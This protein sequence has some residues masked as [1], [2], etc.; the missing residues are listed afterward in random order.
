MGL[1]TTGSAG[2]S[3]EAKTFYDRQLLERTVPK[4]LH[5]KFGQVKSIPDKGGKTIEWRKFAALSTA[6]TPLVEGTLY[7]DLK[8]IVVTAITGTVDQYGDAVGFSDVVD[9]V[10]ID[11]LLAETTKILA[12]QASQTIDEITRDALNAGLTVEYAN[13]AANRAAVAAG[14]NFLQMDGAGGAATG[15]DL[16]DLRLIVLTMELNRARRIGGF[17]Q[18]ITH[19]R[20]MFDI[21][22]TTEW[23][24]LQLYNQTN[25]IVDGSV[26]E[27]YGLKFWTTD[28]AKVF[29]GEGASGIDVYTMLVFGEDAFGTVKLSEGNLETIFKPLGSAGTMDPLNQ[30]QTLGW[31]VTF[32][33]KILQDAF[34]L[35]Y[36]CDVSTA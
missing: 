26:G 13:L 7:N 32:G 10:S 25:R 31:K 14:D 12:E 17:Y 11:P 6:T 27:I 33:T 22:G 24:E 34:M 8:N 15:G 28:V 30:Q 2:L 36:E 20:V 18:V 35:R 3:V 29:A 5:T 23:R 21:Q 19:P 9:V 16:N 1:Q 4:L